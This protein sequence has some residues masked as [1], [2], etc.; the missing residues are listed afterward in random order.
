MM[1]F[2]ALCA[3]LTFLP[4]TG[5]AQTA[6]SA[7]PALSRLSGVTV[8][9]QQDSSA[10]LTGVQL[11]I[12]AGLDRERL[13]QSG[14]AALVAQCILESPSSNGMTVERAIEAA[15]GSIAFTVEPGYVR[16]YVES[17]SSDA[18]NVLTLFSQAF[19]R[20]NF[21]P[22]TLAAARNALT[23]Q[24][25]RLQGEPLHVGVEM[26][27]FAQASGANSGLPRLGTPAS[28]A[29]L[30]PAQAAAFYRAYYVRGGASI[31]AVGRVDALGSQGL[32]ALANLLP[33]KTT[34]A[35]STKVTRLNAKQQQLVARRNVSAPWLIVRYGA[36]PVNSAD[37]GPMLVLSAFLQRTLGDIAQVPGTISPTLASGAVGALYDFNRAPA[38]LVL[39]VDGGIGNASESFGA[40]LSIVRLLSTNKIQGSIDQFKRIAAGDFEERASTLEERAWLAD[41][42]ARR[43]GSPDYLAATLR[44]IQ[45][46]TP[47]DLQRVAHR[48]LGNPTIALVLPRTE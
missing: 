2:L 46:T 17:L 45:A 36:P 35:V 30:T 20:P 39:Y 3:L 41:V 23:A 4:L 11:T 13:S 26:L 15:G 16:F 40:A 37:Y 34:R 10:S 42:F 12:A 33:A 32:T 28:L 6:G 47:D 24:I 38:G 8:V 5:F 31:S 14:L 19:S 22:K 29:Q 9:T 43:T 21:S 44:A 18:S 1:R 7:Q 48:Y 25:T 27:E